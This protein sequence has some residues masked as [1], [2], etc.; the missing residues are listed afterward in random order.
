VRYDKRFNELK[1]AP[2]LVLDDLSLDSATPWAKEKL[3]Q[4]IDYRYVAELPTVITTAANPDEI[5][6]KLQVRMR[7]PRL[8]VVCPITAPMF[9]GGKAAQ[10][11][12]KGY[13]R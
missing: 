12:R 10:R 8:S 1:N 5:D 13:A 2:L 11:K 9:K 6:M 7:D 3:F 4:L